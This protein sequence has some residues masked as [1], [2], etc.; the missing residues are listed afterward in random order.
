MA[1]YDARL[2]ADLQ[3]SRRQLVTSRE[4]ERRRLRR[5]LHDGLGPSLASLHLEAGVLRRLI[6]QDP[7]AAER[8]T[9]EMQ[10]DVRATI[11]DIRR[12]VYELRP[13]ALDD[14]GL[15]P[16]LNVL[17]AKIGLTEGVTAG[18]VHPISGYTWPGGR[19]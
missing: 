1:V 13:P 19:G 18:P 3:R 7:A 17:A 9:E 11:E 16:A 10:G 6:R 4:E 12:V 5:D 8:L 2:T 15:V 14:L